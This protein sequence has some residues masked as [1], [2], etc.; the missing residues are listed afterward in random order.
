[1]IL[2]DTNIYIYLANG[3]IKAEVLNDDIAFASITKVEALGYNQ[4]TVAE[5]SYL[6]ALFAECEQL[7]LDESIIQRS[8][9]LRQQVR[10]TLGDAI[11]AATAIENDCDLW[12]ANT[13]DLIR[14]EGLRLH[15]PLAK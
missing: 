4:I 11:I 10:L 15:N 13:E 1:M 14:I 7:D 6:E 9:R 12:T 3:S 2:L 5:Q 8:I